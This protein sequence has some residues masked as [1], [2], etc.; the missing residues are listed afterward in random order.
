[1]RQDWSQLRVTK[2]QITQ[3]RVKCKEE[4]LSY[5]P[6]LVGMHLSDSFMLQKVMDWYLDIETPLIKKKSRGRKA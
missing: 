1:M 2:E 5:H 6:E 3:L 4:F